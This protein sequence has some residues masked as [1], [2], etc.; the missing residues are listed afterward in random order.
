MWVT[1]LFHAST[2]TDDVV[3]SAAAPSRE[4]AAWQ[5]EESGRSLASAIWTNLVNID[6]FGLLLLGF[7]FAL[8]LAPSSL[9]YT[10]SNGWKNPSLIAMQTIGGVLFIALI[11]WEGWGT[12][13]PLMPTRILNRTF[14][15]CVTIEFLY[16]LSSN[17]TDT[18]WS[19]RLYVIKDYSDR[20]FTYMNQIE[21]V[22]VCSFGLLAGLI[23]RYT[24]RY[25]TL[26]IVSLGIRILGAGINYWSSLGHYNTATLFWAQFLLNLGGCMSVT[27]STVASQAAVPHTDLSIAVAIL[28]LWA[29][30]GG[31]VGSAISTAIWTD[32]LPKQLTKF[33]GDYLSADDIVNIVGDVDVA[34]ASNPHNLIVQ[35]FNATY[36]VLCI[37]QLVI[38][39]IPFIMACFTEDFRLDSRQNAR[40]D[41]AYQLEVRSYTE[42]PVGYE[43][44]SKAAT[45]GPLAEEGE[46]KLGHVGEDLE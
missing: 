11:L 45:G 6:F 2:I 31:S 36:R 40:E 35:A 19:T 3:H 8:L 46:G 43:A 13:R 34:K 30:L 22:T 23:Q 26:Q 21:T 38:V 37:P 4:L 7:S 15:L 39:F 1:R 12:R 9:S 29:S 25:R 28:G 24:H 33:A 16:E 44:Q 18:F 41:T 42:P 32:Q 14:V 17:L 27:C 10:A 20:N 5:G